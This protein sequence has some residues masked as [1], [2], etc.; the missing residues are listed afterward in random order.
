MTQKI[1]V[2]LAAAALTLT[3]AAAT[4]DAPRAE[5]S[6]RPPV[7]ILALGDSYTIGEGVAEDE[8][9]PVQLV[10]A[11]ERRGIP[12]EPP[13]ILARTGWTTAQLSQA[14]DRASLD[15]PYDLVTLLIG[16]NDQFRQYE[17]EAYPDRF[18]SLVD[19]AVALAGDDP[20][21]VLIV[22]IPDYG[23]TPFGARMGASQISQALDRYNRINRE[24][25][26]RAG[27]VHVDITPISREAAD[28][29]SLLARDGLHPS[30]K[31]YARWIELVLPMAE[32]ALRPDPGSETAP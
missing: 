28:D 21:R 27:I 16:V 14:M 8:R 31:M 17:E 3:G 18:E 1:G 20:G 10:S 13:R 2:R 7:R 5:E 30:G 23:V 4:A 9:W 29:T 11:L 15:A 6:P 12:A 25:A 22:S 24:R 32:R 26:A 19:R